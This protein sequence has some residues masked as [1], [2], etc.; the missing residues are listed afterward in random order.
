MPVYSFSTHAATR[1]C[2][3]W[4]IEESLATLR[5]QLPPQFLADFHSLGLSSQ[6]RMGQSLAVR[7]A[8]YTLLK[9]LGFPILPLSKNKQGRPIFVHSSF[10]ISFT[11]TRYA[12]AVALSTAFP[13]GIDLEMVKP[14]LHLVQEKFLTK[15]EIE[16][17]N[18]CLEKLAIYWGAKEALYKRLDGQQC[19]SWKHIVI[20]PFHLHPKGALTAHLHGARYIM[21]YEQM[22][23]GELPPH[24]LVYTEN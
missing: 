10:H 5:L 4:K 13:I 16:A 11:H 15:E 24:V 19:V 17:A 22:I 6:D 14:S 7:V 9:K 3:V 1:F 8:L 12:A 18:H 21:S 23:D 20:E 2:L